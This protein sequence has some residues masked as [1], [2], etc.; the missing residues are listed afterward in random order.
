[1][2][3]NVARASILTPSR[4]GFYQRKSHRVRI[5]LRVISK[6]PAPN[7]ACSHYKDSGLLILT[8]KG[9]LDE[10]GLDSENS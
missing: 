5:L 6:H 10:R 8:V 2:S 7:P 9:F 1:M 4:R 3:P